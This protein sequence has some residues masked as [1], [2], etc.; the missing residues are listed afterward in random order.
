MMELPEAAVLARQVNET[1][2]GKRIKKVL[3]ARTPHRFAWYS[4]EPKKYSELLAGKTIGRAVSFG[5]L[6]EIQAGAASVC[7][8]DGVN[9]RYYPAGEKRPD[10]HQLS[11]EFEDG[12]AL[13]GTIQMYGGFYVSSPD[14]Q[15]TNKYYLAAKGKPSPL[16]AAFDR[17]YFETLFGEG[18]AKLSLKAFLATEQRIP[19]L[20]NG[21]LQD[22]LFNAG[23]HPKKKVGTL[24]GQDKKDL[25]DSIR[26]TLKKMIAVGGRDTEK[27]LFGNFGGYR[28]RLSK[29]TAGRPCP[30]C[31]TTIVKE[32]YMGG[33]VYYCPRCQRF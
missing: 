17:A 2:A 4:G 31:G 5:G 13:I 7:S 20:G 24:S 21:V 33:S 11:V 1:L 23:M 3:A 10:K 9:W 28:T 22:I 19:G 6:L 30:V 26:T 16:S 8:S 32:A 12:S 25:F 18:T 14:T 27:D 29:N 15:V